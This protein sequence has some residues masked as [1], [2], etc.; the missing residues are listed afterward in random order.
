[1]VARGHRDI[2]SSCP[3]VLRDRPHVLCPGTL[4]KVQGMAVM[5]A[6]PCY[7]MLS[8]FRQVGVPACFIWI[9]FDLDL[10]S[11]YIERVSRLKV[12]L[13]IRPEPG[14]MTRRKVRLHSEQETGFGVMKKEEG[15]TGLGVLLGENGL[16]WEGATER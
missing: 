10:V 14:S 16:S 11:P 9:Q 6:G 12:G 4:W 1:M 3:Q 13:E 15:R 5:D 8:L 2:L 7:P